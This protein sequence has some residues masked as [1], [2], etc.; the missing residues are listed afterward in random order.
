MTTDKTIELP[1]G[2]QAVALRHVGSLVDA[3]HYLHNQIKEGLLTE[4]RRAFLLGL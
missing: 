3:A 4:E 1:P 2:E